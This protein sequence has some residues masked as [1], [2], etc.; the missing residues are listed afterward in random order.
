MVVAVS[1]GR[2]GIKTILITLRVGLSFVLPFIISPL[3]WLTYSSTVIRARVTARCA[4]GEKRRCRGGAEHVYLDFSIKRIVSGI[5]Y[6]IGAVIVVT[7][8]YLLIALV[9]GDGNLELE[10]L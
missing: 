8:G 6:V 1:V 4:G 7:N 10:M 2:S 5:A 9:L 3:I